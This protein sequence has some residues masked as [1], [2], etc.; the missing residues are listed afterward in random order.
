MSNTNVN[1]SVMRWSSSS[2]LVDDQMVNTM[3]WYAEDDN[4]TVGD[5]IRDLIVDFYDLEF[6]GD[7]VGNWL[8]SQ[9]LT[10]DYVLEIYRLSDNKP[11]VPWY[12]AS[13]NVDFDS[14]PALPAEVALCLSFQAEKVSGE[15]QA[16]KRNRIYLGGFKSSANVNGRPANELIQVMLFSAEE[17]LQAATNSISVNWIVWSTAAN[18]WHLVE[19]GWV[20]NAWDSQRRRG[21]AP[22]QRGLWD[23][24]SPT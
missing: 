10:G 3:H 4:E 21:L 12:T 15:P 9:S 22:T 14:A 6:D 2:G 8:T 16:R 1:V 20:D 24:N 13:G 19:S 23:I 5:N 17:M 11:R 18:T 7:R